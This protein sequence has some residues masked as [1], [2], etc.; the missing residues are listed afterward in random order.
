MK[1]TISALCLALFSWGAFAQNNSEAENTNKW[2]DTYSTLNQA[3]DWNGMLAKMSECRAEVPNWE[4][5]DYYEGIA[6][7]NLKNYQKAV[8]ALSAFQSF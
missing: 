8:E 1:K 2:I 6:N 3:K 4:F 5:A 7:Y